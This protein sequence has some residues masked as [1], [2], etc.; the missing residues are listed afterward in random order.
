VVFGMLWKGTRKEGIEMS[1]LRMAALS[2][3]LALLLA[4]LGASGSINV[5]SAHH[6]KTHPTAARLSRRSHHHGSGVAAHRHHARH[7]RTHG[8]KKHSK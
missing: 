3:V 1:K 8:Q 4:G 7:T 5:A 6:A 2:G